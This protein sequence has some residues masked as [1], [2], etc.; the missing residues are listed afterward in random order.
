MGVPV[1][2]IGE[3]GSGK[4]RSLK[5]FTRDELG[6]IAVAGKFLPFKSDLKP[7]NINR[8]SKQKHAAIIAPI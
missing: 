8:L 6:I 1:L 2:V 3:S 5:N 4:T 7:I